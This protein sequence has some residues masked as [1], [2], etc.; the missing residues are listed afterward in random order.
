MNQGCAC[1]W[2]HK[3]EKFQNEKTEFDTNIFE[4]ANFAYFSMY[5]LLTL[6]DCIFSLLE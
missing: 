1:M 6:E 2:K 3:T 5:Y 4:G